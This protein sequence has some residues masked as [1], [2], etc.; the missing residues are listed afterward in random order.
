VLEMIRKAICIAV[1]GWALATAAQDTRT[2]AEPKLPPVC[3][4]LEARL[5][6]SP[7]G[8]LLMGDGTS[9]EGALDTNRI[10]KAIDVCGAGKAVELTSH[11]GP[12]GGMAGN[13]YLTGPLDLRQGVTLLI[14]KGV[15]LFGSNDPKDYDVAKGDEPRLCGTSMPRPKELPLFSMDA[16][17]K[18]KGG[19]R[20]LVNVDGAK[21]AAVMGEG[22]ID[23]RGYAKLVGHDY[24]WWQMARKAR[25]LPPGCRLR[26]QAELLVPASSVL[27]LE[28]LT[29][30]AHAA[31]REWPSVYQL[32][33]AA[34][35]GWLAWRQ[36]RPVRDW[37]PPRAPAAGRRRGPPP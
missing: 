34:R 31:W 24:S 5:L 11:V 4:R 12:L 14:D 9:G 17:A 15:T 22:T 1:W 16:A 37:R 32:R 3:V 30:H 7:A 29:G 10:Q 33:P 8:R 2:V 35:P 26:R 21:N 13:A 18:P 23:G 25:A 6:G 36:V 19:C 28:P 20:A 27:T